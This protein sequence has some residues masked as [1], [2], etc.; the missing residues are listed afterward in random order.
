MDIKEVK[1]AVSLIVPFIKMC[2]SDLGEEE[3]VIP[4]RLT[5]EEYEKVDT[6]L[7]KLNNL[8]NYVDQSIFDTETSV[9][10]VNS[11]EPTVDDMIA[12]AE[13]E[14]ARIK[15]YRNDR[16]FKV[17]E[18]DMNRFE[19]MWGIHKG[20][21][22][23]ALRQEIRIKPASRVF[24]FSA[25]IFYWAASTDNDLLCLVNKMQD[26]GYVVE[27]TDYSDAGYP[28]P[29]GKHHMRVSLIPN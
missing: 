2:E 22:F 15:S 28:F 13:S 3:H 16:T 24:Y 21:L 18:E 27:F 12:L 8:N 6:L 1:E 5:S 7:T 19:T 11:D 25:D 4:K 10:E 23:A 29:N 9:E 26:L 20:K 14:S 17:K